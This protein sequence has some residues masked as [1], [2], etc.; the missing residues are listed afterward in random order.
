[1]L[2]EGRGGGKVVGG[3]GDVRGELAT[4]REKGAGVCEVKRVVCC[5]VRLSLGF[6]DSSLFL[7]ISFFFTAF[8]IAFY[9]F[10]PPCFPLFFLAC[11]FPESVHL[12]SYLFFK[13][14]PLLLPPTPFPPSTYRSNQH[15]YLKNPFAI[16][17]YSLTI[18]LLCFRAPL[19]N[20]L[21]S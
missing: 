13:S 9:F 18:F 3:K 5:G 8:L 19:A 2:A 11:C 10:F 7:M 20:P 17:I 14:S 16:S 6:C 4:W 12:A 15:L 1:M 21:S